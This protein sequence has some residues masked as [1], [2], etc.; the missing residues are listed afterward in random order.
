MGA[1]MRN[2]EDEFGLA[3]DVLTLD[4]VSSFLRIPTEKITS[5]ISAGKLQS[6]RI[7]DE[8][9]ILKADLIRYLELARSTPP[10]VPA[11][12]QQPLP[13]SPNG[14]VPVVNLT[15]AQ[16]FEHTWPNRRVEQYKEAYAGNVEFDGSLRSVAIG[17]TERQSAGRARKR[18]VIFVDRRPL[19][20]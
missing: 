17:F 8:I 5:E 13:Q 7:A 10:T 16:P 20:E 19:V 12:K 2:K 11:L 6:L 1:T 14:R 15:T 4:E 3:Q 18:S 9:R